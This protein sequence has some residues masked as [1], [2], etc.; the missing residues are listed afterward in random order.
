MR[1]VTRLWQ[2]YPLFVLSGLSQAAFWPAVAAELMTYF[3]RDRLHA[4]ISFFNI[5][6]CGAMG[7]GSTVAGRLYEWSPGA[8]LEMGA[9]LCAVTS[10]LALGK[11][12]RRETGAVEEPVARADARRDS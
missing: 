10:L 4:G 7:L 9:G 11:A 2:V 8:C 1:H 6:W 5:A 12:S 3:P